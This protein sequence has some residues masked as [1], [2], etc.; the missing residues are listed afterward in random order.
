MI[1]V[2]QAESDADLEAWS[3]V[4]RAVLPNESAWTPQ[5]FRD[6]AEPDRLVLV[7]ELDGEIVGAG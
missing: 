1:R 6:R 5:E 2:R 4:K 7:A 3:R